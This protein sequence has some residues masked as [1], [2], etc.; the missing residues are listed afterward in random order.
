MKIATLLDPRYKNHPSVFPNVVERVQNRTL[1]ITE[2]NILL[3]PRHPP[4]EVSQNVTT[5]TITSGHEDAMSAFLSCASIQPPTEN[6]ESGSNLMF[7]N[8]I[9]AYFKVT[10]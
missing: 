3:N 7:E 8:E 10:N 6:Y 2:L 1:L 9:D 5:T 4:L